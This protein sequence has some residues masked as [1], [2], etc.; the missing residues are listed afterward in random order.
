MSRLICCVVFVAVLYGQDTRTVTE[1]TFP[2][3]CTQLNA[4]LSNTGPSGLPLTSET[5]YDTTRVQGALDLC[6][7]GQAVELRRA[8]ALQWFD[9]PSAFLIGPIRIPPGV[10]LLV[11]AGVTVFASRNP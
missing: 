4:Q 11:D 2:P 1:P 7:P 10:T 6:L 3:V 9:S 8:P 5:M